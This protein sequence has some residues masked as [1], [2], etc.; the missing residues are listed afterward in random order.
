[1]QETEFIELFHRQK[2]AFLKKIKTA[3]EEAGGAA[4]GEHQRVLDN[5]ERWLKGEAAPEPEEG[6]AEPV[7]PFGDFMDEV[8]E[9]AR[10]ILAGRNIK[11]IYALPGQ[12]LGINESWK[13]I[14]VFSNRNIYY[15]IGRTRP[16]KGARR[17]EE[18]LVL[19]LIMD[20]YKKQ[21]FLPMLERKEHLEKLLGETLE[22]ELPKVEATGKYRLKVT[23][24]FKLAREGNAPLVARKLADFITVTRPV[25]N[26]LGVI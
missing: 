10:E 1:M 16:R 14:Q 23:L 20:G 17:G 4:A 12:Y 8:L 2:E 6:A 3:R 5:F 24:P 15:R 13:C 11:I 21:V 26:E 22:R 19:D 7:K 25:L 9:L 18:L